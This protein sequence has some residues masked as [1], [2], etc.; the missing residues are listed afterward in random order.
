MGLGSIGNIRLWEVPMNDQFTVRDYRPEDFK[1][2]AEVWRETGMGS[3]IRGDTAEVVARTLSI[4]G[5]RLLLLEH[6]GDSKVVG[7]SWISC[8][9]RRLFLHHFGI[10]PLFQGRGLSKILLRETLAHAR[11]VKMQIKLEV[12]RANLRAIE[13]YRKGGFEALGEYDVYIIR[14]PS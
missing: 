2:T 5:A 12:H 14:N 11:A 7:T 4:P 10:R 8:D 1:E 6:R 9:G 13:L 3:P